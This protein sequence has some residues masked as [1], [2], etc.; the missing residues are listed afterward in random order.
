MARNPAGAIG[1]Q[2]EQGNA[3]THPEI[4]IEIRTGLL[5]TGFAKADQIGGENMEL[6]GKWLQHR[7]EIADGRRAWA[8][9]MQHQHRKAAAAFKIMD[10][11]PLDIGLARLQC[12]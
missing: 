3:L 11:M 9:A 6:F 10:L 5:A 7:S 4:D 12:H 2:L 1:Q 8:D